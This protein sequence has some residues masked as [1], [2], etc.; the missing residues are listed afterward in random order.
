MQGGNNR[1]VKPRRLFKERLNLR[2]VFAYYTY[3]IAARLVRPR[4]G[5]IIRA[6]LAEAVRR[7]KQL[8]RAVVGNDNLWPMH[9]RRGDKGKVVLSEREGVS[10]ADNDSVI[11]KIGAEEL[12]HHSKRLSGRN[13]RCIG[14]QLHKV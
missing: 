8:V 14:V 12:P 2:A 11:R 3:I 7:E 5:Y 10:L 13:H 1:N 4:L 9:H 6:E